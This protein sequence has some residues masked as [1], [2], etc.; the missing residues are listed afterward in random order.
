MDDLRSWSIFFIGIWGIL[1]LVVSSQLLLLPYEIMFT[2]STGGPT[3]FSDYFLKCA[4]FVFLSVSLLVAIISCFYYLFSSKKEKINPWVK[5]F[6]FLPFLSVAL[7]VPLLVFSSTPTATS[8]TEPSS[9]EK[10]NKMD[11]QISSTTILKSQYYYL[12]QNK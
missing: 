5:I 3:S 4:A 1:F 2:V 10:L 7:C 9:A 11:S 8:T 12:Y 6:I